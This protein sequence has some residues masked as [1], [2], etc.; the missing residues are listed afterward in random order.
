MEL[1]IFGKLNDYLPD[2]PQWLIHEEKVKL[3]RA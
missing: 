3:L 2:K 1:V